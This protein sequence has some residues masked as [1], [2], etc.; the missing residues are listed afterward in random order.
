ME[1]NWL[2][3]LMAI[4]FIYNIYNG[5]RLGFV[6]ILFSLLG[7]FVSLIISYVVT[8]ALATVFPWP[9]PVIF[10]IAFIATNIVFALAYIAFDLAAHLPVLKHVN[11]IAGI[12]V[13]GINAF[14]IAWLI[15]AVLAFL[16]STNLGE[17]AMQCISQS[18][19]LNALYA[20]DVFIEALKSIK[21]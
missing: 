17:S 3:I 20:S 2:L 6:R 15:M 7:I 5:W 18:K 19:F 4:I 12:L 11:K 8:P 13:G 16:Q 9:R 10:I 14:I 21:I 1:I